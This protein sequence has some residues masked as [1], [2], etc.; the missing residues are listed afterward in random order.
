MFG[1]YIGA[2]SRVS[3]F[4]YL[5]DKFDLLGPS[6]QL[7]GF[8]MTVREQYANGKLEG[9]IKNSKIRLDVEE[10]VRRGDVLTIA[11]GITNNTASSLMIEGSIKSSAGAR[12]PVDFW[13]S[14]AE[15][16]ALAVGEKKTV[17]LKIFLPES[18]SVKIVE[19]HFSFGAPTGDTVTAIPIMEFK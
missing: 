3:A 10:V 13:D 12:G 9:A 18:L 7:A 4:R 14:R 11:F 17:S 5:G 15:S 2:D 16:F 8:Q 19:G 1:T 6:K